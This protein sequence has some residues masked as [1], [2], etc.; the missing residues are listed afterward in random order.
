M[1]RG[2]FQ[3]WSKTNRD[4][5]HQY[6]IAF[7][8][9]RLLP[10]RLDREVF[11][12]SLCDE[13]TEAIYRR[14]VQGFRQSSFSYRDA[15]MSRWSDLGFHTENQLMLEAKSSCLLRLGQRSYANR[16]ALPTDQSSPP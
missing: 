5:R 11:P 13:C 4:R 16:I 8:S 15:G 6:T 7:Q 12:D 1:Q 3:T 2:R 14:F 10:H 9:L